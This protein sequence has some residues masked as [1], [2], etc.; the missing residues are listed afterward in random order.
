M[1]ETTYAIRL[2]FETASFPSLLEPDARPSATG[3]PPFGY[4]LAH[5][6]RIREARLLREQS[7]RAAQQAVE[8]LARIRRDYVN[9][10]LSPDDWQEFRDELEPERDAARAEASRHAAQ[11]AELESSTA[12]EDA[13]TEVL[14]RLAETRASIAGDVASQ[15]SL[16]SIRAALLTLFSGF[17]VHCTALGDTERLPLLIHADLMLPGYG[18]L[19][20]EPHVRPE[21]IAERAPVGN[22]VEL[23]RV[24][25]ALAGNI[26]SAPTPPE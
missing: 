11:E 14:Q 21:A 13:E 23:H 19:I 8:R 1:P 5:D 17:T 22:A 24:P 15:T 18:G 9:G 6:R 10:K 7:E 26:E 20:V 4:A 16:Q 2:M 12:I 3:S 25:L